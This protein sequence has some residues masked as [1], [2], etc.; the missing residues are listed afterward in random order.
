[1]ITF[2][3]YLFV[4]RIQH[5]R[6]IALYEYSE[7]NLKWIEKHTISSLSVLDPLA[8]SWLIGSLNVGDIKFYV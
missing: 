7:R 3:Y 1:M 4:V 8:L 5:D 2:V 6:L